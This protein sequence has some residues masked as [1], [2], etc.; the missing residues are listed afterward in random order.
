MVISKEDK[1]LTKSLHE[2]KGY[3]ICKL[4]K[5]FLKKNWTKGGL[6]NDILIT[7]LRNTGDIVRKHGSGRPRSTCTDKALSEVADPEQS[8]IDSAII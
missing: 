7:K 8:I 5:Q 2:T 6:D 4:L 1:I 3:H